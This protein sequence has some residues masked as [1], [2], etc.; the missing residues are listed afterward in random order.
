VLK[1]SIITRVAKFYHETGI[2]LGRPMKDWSYH[3]LVTETC[4]RSNG[5]P[6]LRLLKLT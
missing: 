4:R 1:W 5:Q 3:A 6:T 2:V